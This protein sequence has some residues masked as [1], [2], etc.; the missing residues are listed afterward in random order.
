MH[1]MTMGSNA[2]KRGD[3]SAAIAAQLRAER[4]AQGLTQEQLASKAG[5]G[6]QMLMRI[7]KEERVADVSQVADLVAA[8]GIGLVEFFERTEARLAQARPAARRDVA[9][10]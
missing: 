3:Y 9:G 6:R 2:R 8:L 10:G 7:E 1:C 5:M 4:A